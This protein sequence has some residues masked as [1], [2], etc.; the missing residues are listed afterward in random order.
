MIRS[1]T[2]GQENLIFE[3]DSRGHRTN[4]INRPVKGDVLIEAGDCD[5]VVTP[6]DQLGQIRVGQAHKGEIL[7]VGLDVA[8]R[9]LLVVTRR[10]DL[11]IRHTS[12]QVPVHQPALLLSPSLRPNLTI[13]P[14]GFRYPYDSHPLALK[15][16]RRTPRESEAERQRDPA[17][18]IV[19]HFHHS[20]WR[21]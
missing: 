21:S 4:I 15:H 20:A 17:L 7:T 10:P 8:V 12:Y 11:R 19:R 6:H 5:L 3:I 13:R 16:A 1:L 9:T 2:P 18:P 14:L